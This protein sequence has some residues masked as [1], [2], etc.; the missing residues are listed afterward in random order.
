MLYAQCPMPTSSMDGMIEN[1]YFWWGQRQ[2]VIYLVASSS[3]SNNKNY[4][5]QSMI[6]HVR[7]LRN[8]YFQGRGMCVYT[9]RSKDGLVESLLSFCL[10]MGSGHSNSGSYNCTEVPYPLSYFHSHPL[11]SLPLFSSPSTPLH[12][13]FFRGSWVHSPLP[14]ATEP[15]Y[16]LSLGPGS[17][18][19]A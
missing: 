3:N 11:H 15:S 16:N 18:R 9:W 1:L 17:H 19:W 14:L 8:C 12:P 10:Y 7:N 4:N 2:T 5:K 13:S 6:Y